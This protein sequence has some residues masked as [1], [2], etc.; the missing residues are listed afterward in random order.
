[1]MRADSAG[2][3]RQHAPVY[4]VLTVA[5][6]LVAFTAM[7]DITTGTQPSFMREWVALTLCVTWLAF[8][9]VRLLR[10]RR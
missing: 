4:I 10:R 7:D 8:M 5:A 1:M 9:S 6:M 3:S 2:S